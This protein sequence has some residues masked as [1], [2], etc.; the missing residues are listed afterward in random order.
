[1]NRLAIWV[2]LYLL[3]T[4]QVFT[5]PPLSTKLWI[6]AAICQNTTATLNWDTSTTNAPVAVC[7]T[8]TNTQKGVAVFDGTTSKS[9]QETLRLPVDWAIGSTVWVRLPWYTGSITNA[10]RW[11]A[12]IVC[13]ADGATDDPAF[14]TGVCINDTAKGTTLQVNDAE[15]QIDGA[16]LDTC[17]VGDMLL[18]L[19]VYREPANAGDTMD[20]VDAALIGAQVTYQRTPRWY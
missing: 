10:A 7:A 9:M 6:P 13:V 8:G 1:M 15:V 17:T 4:A 19:K 11:C 18:H 20:G 14:D 3:T 2:L 12:A 5:Q 16:S